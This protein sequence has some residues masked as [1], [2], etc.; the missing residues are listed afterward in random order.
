MT[1]IAGAPAERTMFSTSRAP[2]L[3]LSYSFWPSVRTVEVLSTEADIVLWL[4]AFGKT[5]G[6]TAKQQRWRRR[7][8]KKSR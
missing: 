3:R 5:A 1:H 4:A 8:G 7:P 6:R 2:A